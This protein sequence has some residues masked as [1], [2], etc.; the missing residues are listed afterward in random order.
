MEV[1]GTIMWRCSLPGV[2]LH[3]SRWNR[4]AIKAIGSHCHCVGRDM[5]RFNFPHQANGTEFHRR[6]EWGQF[7][8]S[9]FFPPLFL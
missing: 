1:D 9:S 7:L 3:L 8:P 2:R 6:F 5:E 4:A